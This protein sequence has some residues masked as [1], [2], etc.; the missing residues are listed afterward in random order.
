MILPITLTVAGA[1][2]LLNIWL[3]SRVSRLRNQFKISVGDGG[4]EALLRRMR[5]QANY[6]ET[7]PF[8]L[9]LIGLLELAGGDG[10]FL[11]AAAIL[12]ILAR[13][14]HGFGMDGGRLKR[15]RSIGMI[16]STLVLLA[17]AGW[18]LSYAYRQPP[19][20]RNEIRIGPGRSA[21]ASNLPVPIEEISRLS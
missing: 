5:A 1:A 18:A 7:A 12:F 11:W 6:I 14:A 15:L 8:F 20:P 13:I 17:V 3:A 21:S 9:I 10:R 19:E 4:N 2:T 16:V